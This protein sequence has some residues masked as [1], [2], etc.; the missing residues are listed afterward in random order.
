MRNVL[1]FGSA[2][3]VLA[4]TAPAFGALVGQWNLDESSG[5]TAA[6]ASSG[7]YPS[8]APA[9]P[10]K[11]NGL[12]QGAAA[13]APTGGKFGGAINLTGGGYVKL[14]GGATGNAAAN[15]G[16]Q[17]FTL[18]AWIKRTAAGT[19]AN[20][21][22]GGVT[23]VIPILCKGV[24]EGDGS[25]IDANYFFGIDSN[26]GRLAADFETYSTTTPANPNGGS[27]TNFGVWGG[28]THLLPVDANTWHHVAVT[29]DGRY[30]M[31]YVDGN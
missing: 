20:S 21:G 3:L 10:V 23:S 24:G 22:T 2:L 14:T 30:W 12:L 15:L 6:D 4:C 5:T 13:F 18:M 1:L 9:T 16:V 29:W 27:G 26:S 8:W 11:D 7:W 19:A 25:N 28:G 31:L 17:R